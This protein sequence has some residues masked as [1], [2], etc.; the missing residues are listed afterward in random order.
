MAHFL[1]KHFIILLETSFTKNDSVNVNH[2]DLR[3]TMIL[4]ID[5]KRIA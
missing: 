3:P 4:N 2:P 1:K 5:I